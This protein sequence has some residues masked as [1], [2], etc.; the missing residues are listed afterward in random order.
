MHSADESK[1]HDLLSQG[2]KVFGDAYTLSIVRMLSSTTQRFNELQRSLG[3]ISPTTLTDRLKKL[4]NLGLIAQEKQTI[5][6]LS[7]IYA[8]TEKG[9]KMLPVLGAI[10]SFSKKFL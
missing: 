7:V 8:L 6:Q 1:K 5:D 2:F 3:N 9:K 4:E 10:E